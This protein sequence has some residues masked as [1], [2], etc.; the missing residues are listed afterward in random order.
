MLALRYRYGADGTPQEA[1]SLVA[2]EERCA[3]LVAPQG[4][5][6][7]ASTHTGNCTHYG[8]THHGCTY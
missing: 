7:R 5:T 8:S 6:V 2:K 4:A 3:L 1:T